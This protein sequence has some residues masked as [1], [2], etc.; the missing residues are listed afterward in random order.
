MENQKNGNSFLGLERVSKLLKMFAIPCVLSLIIQALYNLVD[1]VFIGHCESLGAVGNAATGIVYPITVVALGIGL[2]LGDG[3][4]AM[5]S[6][7][8]GKNKFHE[9]EK[10]VGTVFSIGLIAGV[11]LTTLVLL[12]R[13][14]I[15]QMIGASDKILEA[16]VE[17]SVFISIGF[18]FFMLAC[19]LNPIIRADGSPKYA[20][21]AMAI[22]A[23][24]NIILDPIFIF[25]FDMGMTGAGLATFLG[26]VITFALHVAYLFKSKTFKLNAR[27]FIPR[28]SLLGKSMKYGISSFLTQL[29]IVIISIVNNSL[30]FKFSY[31]SGYDPIV[32]QGAITL[33]FKVFGI[34]VSI[35]IG[36]ASG[37]QPIIGY[38]YGAKKYKRVRETFKIIMIFTLIV[39]IISTILFEFC[40]K[41]FLF[42]F[43]DGGENV[44]KAMYKAF[45]MST[46]RIY[47][48]FILLTCIIKASAI[49][50]QSTGHTIF[51][52]VVSMSRDLIILVPVAILFANLKGVDLLLWSAPVSDSVSLII[53]GIILF[54]IFKKMP[55]EDLG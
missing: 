10:I 34:V 33:A 19:V 42:I 50:L 31:N 25:V 44:D 26:Q 15:M 51:A 3:A 16:A 20:M 49:F 13:S 9:S 29:A 41:I 37:G 40:P 30:L 48:G 23:I 22:G 47:L 1:Q 55:K 12:F 2:W 46:F 14:E 39:G 27:S 11:I 36:I 17:Y 38:N 43:G 35:I 28:F 53:T 54:Y 52:A 6:I 45:T 7:N 18:V 32:T 8:Q 5:I 21:L 4:S 24:I